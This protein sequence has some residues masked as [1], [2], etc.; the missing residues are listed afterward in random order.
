MS[1]SYP[2]LACIKWALRVIGWSPEVKR[3][4]G[5]SPGNSSS[6]FMAL[7]KRSFSRASSRITQSTLYIYSSTLILHTEMSKRTI[8]TCSETPSTRTTWEHVE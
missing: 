4:L 7:P 1:D 2:S 3:Y 8:C 5:T 6:E